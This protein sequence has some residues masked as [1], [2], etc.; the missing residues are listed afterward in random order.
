MRP[1]LKR[2]LGILREEHELG[3]ITLGYERYLDSER[4]LSSYTIN[5]YLSDLASFF[6]FIKEAEVID[7]RKVDRQLVR[8]YVAWLSRQTV[9]LGRNRVKQGYDKPSVSRKLSALRSLFRYLVREG[10]VEAS[11]LWKRGSREAKALTPKLDKRLPS[12]LA[13]KEVFHLLESP[14]LS[15]PQGLRDR[16]ML[17]ILYASGLRVSE[18]AKLKLGDIDPSTRE[19]RVWGKGSKERV[20]LAGRPAL[21]ALDAY[22]QQGRSQLL[23]GKGTDSLFLNKYGKGISERSVQAIVKKHARLS[24]LDQRVHPHVLRH[25]F[26][27]HLLDGGADLR[28]VQ[29]L[30]GHQNLSTTQIYTHITQSEARKSYM[31]AHPRA[32]EERKAS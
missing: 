2:L 6:R 12:F 21:S 22:I 20:V 3:D 18:L 32:R 28:V 19:V 29:E 7:L 4:G 31:K 14:D 23:K 25:T 24:G 16:A 26:A 10:E 15:T 30:L 27:T 13:I 11:P 8:S 17:E 9:K 5:N 1:S